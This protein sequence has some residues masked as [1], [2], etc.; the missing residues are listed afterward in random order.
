M[1]PTGRWAAGGTDQLAGGKGDDRLIAGRGLARLGAESA[2]PGA[3]ALG[4]GRLG[5]EPTREPSNVSLVS[6]GGAPANSSAQI[7]ANARSGGG[8]PL[9]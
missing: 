4:P 5:P 8:E 1:A 6:D 9:P 7:T 2:A 3:L